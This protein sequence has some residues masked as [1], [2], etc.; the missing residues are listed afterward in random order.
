MNSVVDHLVNGM[1]F[2]ALTIVVVLSKESLAIK[3][4][5]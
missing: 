5:Q 1:K 4:G 2:P 3:V